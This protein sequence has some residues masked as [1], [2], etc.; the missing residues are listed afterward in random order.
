MVNTRESRE[1]CDSQTFPIHDSAYKYSSRGLDASREILRLL[2]KVFR[3]TVASLHLFKY[4]SVT[5]GELSGNH[6]LK[7]QSQSRNFYTLT[8]K[9][10]FSYS[11]ENVSKCRWTEVQFLMGL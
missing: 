6:R 4:S 2:T 5:A 1:G 11:K 3:F 7:A 8:E 9:G 10:F